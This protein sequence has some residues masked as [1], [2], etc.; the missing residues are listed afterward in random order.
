MEMYEERQRVFTNTGKS[1]CRFN[2]EASNTIHNQFHLW[3][4]FF[5][6]KIFALFCLF[7]FVES[8]KIE[9]LGT[10]SSINPKVD[11][12]SK[13]PVTTLPRSRSWQEPQ[14]WHVLP[15]TSS[16]CD[17]TQDPGLVPCTW[18]PEQLHTQPRARSYREGRLTGL[19][20]LPLQWEKRA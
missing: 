15:L 12:A 6:I 5:T 20:E 3:V 9:H 4:I 14:G 17:S 16:G 2:W 13:C 19:Q 18:H 10:N 7:C 11:S 8:I 1:C